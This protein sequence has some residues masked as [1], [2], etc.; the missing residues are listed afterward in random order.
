[1]SNSWEAFFC[2]TGNGVSI[3]KS[4]PMLAQK[5]EVRQ[6]NTNRIDKQHDQGEGN[7]LLVSGRVAVNGIVLEQPTTF[8]FTK[9]LFVLRKIVALEIIWTIF[10]METMGT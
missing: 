9:V 4:I 5:H 7:V 2:F 3:R 10:R 8:W 6:R 1:M